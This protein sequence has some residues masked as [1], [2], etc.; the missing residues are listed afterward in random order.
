M[1]IL[2]FIVLLVLNTISLVIAYKNK[3]DIKEIE[4][5]SN[6]RLTQ[7]LI[8]SGMVEYVK[9]KLEGEAAEK[10]KQETKKFKD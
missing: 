10:L 9:G 2:A 7:L 4:L 3:K 5:S 8:S 6:S 1:S